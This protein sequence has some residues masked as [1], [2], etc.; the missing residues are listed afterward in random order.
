[1]TPRTHHLFTKLTDLT[2]TIS[3]KWSV[4]SIEFLSTLI[5]LSH[6]TT[7][8]LYVDFDYCSM[9]NIINNIRYLLQQT[10]NVRSLT[11]SNSFYGGNL[12]MVVGDLCHIIPHHIKHLDVY[13]MDI[14]D[15]KI[16]LTRLKYLSSITFVFFFDMPFSPNEIIK[17]LSERT[18][19]TYLVDNSSL[20]LWLGKDINASPESILMPTTLN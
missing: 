7:L 2:L 20:S 15:I 16:L 14:N 10:Y 9:S 17:W 8:G 13:D 18:D 11:L 19:F 6:L 12:N 4:D 5:D 3:G 1:M